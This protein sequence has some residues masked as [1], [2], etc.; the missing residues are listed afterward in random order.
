MGGIGG[1]WLGRARIAASIP[2]RMVEV[3]RRSE[4]V[5]EILSGRIDTLSSE[6]AELRT[7]LNSR[8]AAETELVELVGRLLQS[9]EGRLEVLEDTLSTAGAPASDEAADE[10]TQAQS[11]APTANG[12]A[13]LASPASAAAAAGRQTTVRRP[14]DPKR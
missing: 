6:I 11:D 13:Q 9:A 7:L 5:G 4:L 3:E 14:R 1:R 8:L 10:G 12:S 2:E